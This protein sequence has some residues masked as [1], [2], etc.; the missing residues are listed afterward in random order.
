MLIGSP[1]YSDSHKFLT[2]CPTPA[3]LAIWNTALRKLS[4]AFLVLTVKIQEYIG[5]PISSLL[6]LLGDLGTTL[7]HNMVRENKLYYEVYLPSSNTFAHRTRSGHRYDS[8]LIVIWT[9]QFSTM[10]KRDSITGWAGLPS[11]LAS[12]L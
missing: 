11:L 5:P 8:K 9:F 1:G 10:C 12:L 4:L 2:Q 3:D 6:W 7:H